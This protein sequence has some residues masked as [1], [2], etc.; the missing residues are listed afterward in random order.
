MEKV[1]SS[2]LEQKAPYLG[3]ACDKLELLYQPKCYVI[4]NITQW[5]HVSDQL[6][7]T[8]QSKAGRKNGVL[9]F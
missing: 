8:F 4:L 2:H 7:K 3:Q 5:E 9:T 1:H 6:S